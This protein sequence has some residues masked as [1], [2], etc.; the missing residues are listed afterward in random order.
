MKI[1]MISAGHS[2]TDP[3]ITRGSLREADFTLLIRNKI[4]HYLKLKNFP[5]VTDGQDGINFSLP[6]AIKIGKEVNGTKVEI[7]LNGGPIDV[8]H[9]TEALSLPKH[10]IQSQALC[11]AVHDV[12]GFKLRGN[13]GWKDQSSGAH[14]RLG[15][16]LMGGIILEVCFLTNGKEME[17]LTAKIN[18]LSES[19]SSCLIKLNQ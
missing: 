9:G 16:C 15:F 11:Q 14:S 2:N 5:H 7:H 12:L 18:D 19:I 8:A 6:K 13:K 3:G 4:H 17:K 10:K 1:V